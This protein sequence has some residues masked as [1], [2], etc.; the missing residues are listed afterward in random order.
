M[1]RGC[2]RSARN[3]RAAGG[4]F[5]IITARLSESCAQLNS[6]KVVQKTRVLVIEYKGLIVS[7][8]VPWFVFSLHFVL[9]P[10]ILS[11]STT[12]CH[13]ES[14]PDAP[15]VKLKYVNWAYAIYS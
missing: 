5:S 9:S 13:P 10:A 12:E 14:Q 8:F 1:T 6:V 4:S 3:E 7:C 15:L 2:V 11:P